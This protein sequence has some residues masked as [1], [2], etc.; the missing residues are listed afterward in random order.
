MTQLE[1]RLLQLL[2]ASCSLNKKKKIENRK[3]LNEANTTKHPAFPAINGD[4]ND[5]P[6]LH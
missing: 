3:S 6:F 1:T 4:R 2:S 5:F